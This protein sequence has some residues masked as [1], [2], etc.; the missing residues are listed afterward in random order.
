MT[1][2]SVVMPG[3]LT[4]IFLRPSARTPVRSVSETSAVPGGG[5]DGDHAGGGA[6]QVTILSE[7]A[8]RDV[9]NELGKPDLEIVVP[10]PVG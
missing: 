2:G 4:R 6:R 8:W 9:R 10:E 1:G 3:A 7:E 5:L